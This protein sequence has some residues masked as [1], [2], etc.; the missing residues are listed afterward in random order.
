MGKKGIFDCHLS[1]VRRKMAI[2]NSVYN[3]FNISSY[4]LLEFD[5]LRPR[6][7]IQSCRDGSSW[8]KIST[9]QGVMCLAQGHNTVPPVRLEP[10]IYLLRFGT[11]VPVV[12]I[13][14]R[15]WHLLLI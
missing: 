15:V 11:Q 5:S 1:P 9:K 4:F 6:Q 12:V 2:E 10:A 3:D 8:Y 13:Q 7:K 14:L